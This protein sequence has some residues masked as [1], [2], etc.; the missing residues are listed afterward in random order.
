MAKKQTKSIY[1]F[2]IPDDFEEKFDRAELYRSIRDNKK[3][4]A[5][6][7]FARAVP[8]FRD[9]LIEAYRRSLY[10]L[11]NKKVRNNGKTVKSALIVGDIIGRF[12]PHGDQSAYQGIVTLSQPWTNNEPLIYGQGNWGNVL[13]KSAAHYRYTEC[14]TSEF[15]DDVCE[16]IKREYVDFIPNF[17]GSDIEIKYIPFKIPVILVNGS[18]GIADSYI[19]SILPHNLSDVVDL[20]EKYIHNKN[21]KN[22]ILVDGFYPDFPNY[23]IILNKSEIEAAYKYNIQGNVKMKATL[24]VDRVENRITIKDLPYNVCESDVLNILKQQN[25]KQHAVLSKVY[26]LI[27]IKTQRDGE[28]HVEYDVVFDKNSNILEVARDLEK[29][30][31]SKTIP[32]SIIMYDDGQQRVR[33]V[34]IK[35]I[36][37]AWYDTIYTTKLRRIGYQ[38]TNLKTQIHILEGKLK[39]YDHVDEI[40]AYAKQ[41]QNDE[42]FINYLSKNFG[43]TNIQANAIINMK[44]AQLNQ[45]SKSEIQEQIEANIKKIEDLDI[46]AMHIDDAIIEDLEFLRKKY[47][48]PR[49]TIVL[50]DTLDASGN[51]ESIPMSNGAILWTHNQYAIFDIQNIINGKALTNG[52][53][54]C[55]VDGKN[56]KDII[57]CHNISDDLKG[58]LIFFKDGTAKKIPISEIFDINNW[59]VVDND[60]VIQA[61]VPI[62]SDNDKYIIISDSDK[63]RM[64]GIDQ[65]GNQKVTTGKIKLVQKYDKTK[66]YCFIITSSGRYHLIQ[67]SDIPELGRSAA[68]V[69]ISLPDNE[70][71]SMIQIERFSDDVGICSIMDPDGY[72]YIMKAE[73]ELLEDTNR[74]NKTKKLY[75]LGNGYVLSD[76]SLVNT[77]D[78]NSKCVLIGRNSSSQISMQNIRSSDMTKIPKKVPVLSVGIV[79]YSL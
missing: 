54:T 43:L 8:S 63:I 30:C 14:K 31:L 35:D 66:D 49:R 34:S 61:I 23:G 7:T 18:Y 2:D 65:F 70:K 79:T 71:I 50:D 46:A 3:I 36:V 47:G 11:I 68:G 67:T 12:H 58:I 29:L 25:Q 69:M 26:D 52:I 22:E 56:N 21:I 57:G 48:R 51:I 41:N 55:K 39:I 20:C 5:L 13:G 10:D 53:K 44:I 19:T 24:E 32:L 64:V 78:K 74:V 38:Q 75:E 76:V 60:P 40:I 16:D 9:G 28:I 45:T 6:T 1:S 37:A 72:S 62:N 15:F 73:Q 27:D 4:Y 17:D 42:S 59:V 77:K 33:K